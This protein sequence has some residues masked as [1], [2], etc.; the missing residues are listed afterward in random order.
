V[1][2]KSGP[3]LSKS[4]NRSINPDPEVNPYA[5]ELQDLGVIDVKPNEPLNV[6]TPEGK[7]PVK[8]IHESLERYKEKNRPQDTLRQ[9]LTDLAGS[10]V[11]YMDGSK[12]RVE[13]DIE[14]WE[15]LQRII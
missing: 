7:D 15:N 6:A 13:I 14:A 4:N 3:P 1:I 2:N 12:V 10:K 5:A 8:R 11:I 9:L